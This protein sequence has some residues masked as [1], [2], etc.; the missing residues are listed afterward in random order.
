[1]EVKENCG[2]EDEE[3]FEIKINIKNI[4]EEIKLK[5]L[6]KEELWK[7]L[8]MRKTRKNGI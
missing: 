4:L 1:M 6:V 3:N 7:M 5:D 2:S 8:M